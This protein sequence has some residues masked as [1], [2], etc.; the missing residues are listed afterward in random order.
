MFIPL[1]LAGCA[2]TY[3]AAPDTQ[4]STAQHALKA[5]E[6][7]QRAAEARAESAWHAYDAGQQAQ[8]LALVNQGRTYKVGPSLMGSHCELL[9]MTAA[10]EAADSDELA[11]WHSNMSRNT[12]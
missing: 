7:R 8:I 4:L 1:A 5:Q 12:Q 9:A 11:E 6:F 10:R 3:P 2:A